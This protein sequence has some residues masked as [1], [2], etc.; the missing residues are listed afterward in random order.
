M[1]VSALPHLGSQPSAGKIQILN[2]WGLHSAGSSFTVLC[3]TWTGISQSLGSAELIIR[4]LPWGLSVS[5]GLLLP[6]GL[7]S[8][9]TSHRG[10]QRSKR[11]SK[12]F[13]VSYD[14]TLEVV[15]YRFCH[16]LWIP[17]EL[18]RSAQVSGRWITDRRVARLHCP[19][20][21][22]V[23]VTVS[24]IFEKHT[25]LRAVIALN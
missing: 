23:G 18:L 11:P 7:D 24:T 17:G 12:S 13:K 16:V 6:W 10:S 8:K 25:L 5:L 14:I 9:G 1:L 22:G 2:F 21:C 3:S 4:T 15:Q 19:R 20:T